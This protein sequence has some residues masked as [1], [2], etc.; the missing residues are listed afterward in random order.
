LFISF[1]FPAIAVRS[2]TQH[3]NTDL[4]AHF[5]TA[6]QDLALLLIDTV[7]SDCQWHAF[8]PLHV[9]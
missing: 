8:I 9:A 1:S 4:P 7:P 6:Q 2:T 5:H 3:Q